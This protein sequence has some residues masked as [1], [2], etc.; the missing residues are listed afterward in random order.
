MT[1]T[2]FYIFISTI[3][4]IVSGVV[5][6][7]GILSLFLFITGAIAGLIRPFFRF[8]WA[9]WKKKVYIVAGEKAGTFEGDLVRSGIVKKRNIECKNLDQLA[10]IQDAR[11]IILDY[12]FLGS[13][14][15]LEIIKRKKPNCGAIVYATSREI[16]SKSLEELYEV[17]HVS[18][19]NFRGRLVN[20]VLVLLMSCS[21]SKKDAQA[22]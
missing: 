7:V 20:E 18:V 4:S 17:Q 9:A 15:T 6:I 11:L 5:T 10:D 19:A 14:K 16:D 2:T 13:K 12:K 8:G 22:Q 1:D 3:L 21:F